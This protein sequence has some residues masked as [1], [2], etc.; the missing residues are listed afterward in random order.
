MRC[1]AAFSCRLPLRLSRWRARF[2]D[3]TGSG[4]TA[5]VAGVGVGALEAVDAGG[6]AEDLRGRERPAAAD[7]E[8]R[9]SE[10]LDETLTDRP[11]WLERSVLALTGVWQ[12]VRGYF[13]VE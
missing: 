13:P 10:L 7:R 12:P 4:A 2:D 5:V 1:R 9:R 8:Q 6:L 11:T 3:Q